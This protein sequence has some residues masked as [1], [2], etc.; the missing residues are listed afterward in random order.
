MK[1]AIL[2][3]N[4]VPWG[5]SEILWTR[6]AS[7]WHQQGHQVA[8]GIKNWQPMPKPVLSLEEAGIPLN[9]YESILGGACNKQDNG[10]RW[11]LGWHHPSA[12]A[13]VE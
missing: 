2:P 4:V 3:L 13:M 11:F 1:I 9:R 5:G 7:H 12:G 6:L 10:S 8:V